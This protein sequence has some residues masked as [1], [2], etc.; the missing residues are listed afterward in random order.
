TVIMIFTAITVFGIIS[1]QKLPVN[2]LPDIKYPS[3]TVWTELEGSSPEQIERLVT[4]P[5]EASIAG[6]KDIIKIKSESKESISLITID[7][8]WGTDMDFAVLYLREKLDAATLPDTAGRPNILRVDP[9]SKPIIILSISGKDLKSV[10]DISEHIIKK[11]IEQIEGVAMADVIGGEEVDIRIEADIEKLN[12]Y[13]L[14]FTNL[15][16]VIKSAST[17]S[18]GGTVKDDVYIY[19][20]V[21]SSEFKNL[22]DIEN[23]LIKQLDNKRNIYVKDVAAV[24]YKSK[25][26]RSF[27]RYNA[28]SS[29]AILIR[30]DGDANAVLVADIVKTTIDELNNNLDVNIN[31]VYDQSQFI[32]DSINNVVS[33]ILLGGLLSF[34]TLFLFLREFKSPFNI[35]LAMPISIFST[36]TLFYFSKISLNLMSLSGFAL[37]IGMLVD[38]SIVVLENIDRHR[39]DTANIFE[40]CYIGVKEVILPVSASTFT[41]IIVF[42]PVVFVSGVAGEL[43]KDQSASVA[44]ALISSLFVSITL[45]PVLYNKMVIGKKSDTLFDESVKS[46]DGPIFKTG[47]YWTILILIYF[48]IVKISK[49]PID[50]HAFAYILFLSVLTDPI[51]KSIEFLIFHRKN[52]GIDFK[53]KIKF[54]GIN[55]VWFVL[56]F[57]LAIPAAYISKVDYFEPIHAF[58]SFSGLKFL[59]LFDNMLYDFSSFVNEL[60]QPYEEELSTKSFMLYSY[61]LG[62]VVFIVNL[63]GLLNPKK[64][65][66]IGKDIMDDIFFIEKMRS[67]IKT[68]FKLI[69]GFIIGLLMFYFNIAIKSFKFI[70]KPV[71]IGFDKS[72][73][74]FEN[75]YHEILIKALNNKAWTF[76]LSI[77]VLFVSYLLMMN[78][79]KR[80]M[81]DVDSR[82]FILSI[83]LN[84]GTSIWTTES[85]IQDY[86]QIIIQKEGVSSAFS[87]G[88]I[89][90]EKSIL[91]GATVYK[92]DIQVKLEDNVSTNEFI[93]DLRKDIHDYNSNKDLDIKININTDV[94]VL[95]EML[96]ADEGDISIKISGNNLNDLREITDTVIQKL[97][98]FNNLSEIKSDFS[99]NKPQISINFKNSFLEDNNLS[100]QEISSYIKTMIKGE[101]ATQITENNK[102]IDI[103][104]GTDE[105][106]NENIKNILKSIYKKNG[107][108]YPVSKL[109]E[110]N[111][112]S[113]PEAIRHESQ[114][115]VITVTANFTEGRL[116]QAVTEIKAEMDKINLYRGM[117][118]DV[119]GQNTEMEKSMTQIIFMFLLSF[120]LVYMVLASQFE[121]LLSPLIIVLSVPFAFIGVAFGLFITGQSINILS[122]IG[123]IM[124]VGI[125]VNDAIVKVDFIENSVK[126]GLSVRDAIID[127][128]R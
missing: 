43:F 52:Q 111:F 17:N 79:E 98:E 7:F 123:M 107:K 1:Y 71:F 121:S 74:L 58:I 85:V 19:D 102:T 23:T 37:G 70:F 39:Q 41:T 53:H 48:S 88:G 76:G 14:S 89:Y 67:S 109:I 47:I 93:N 3:L 73:N 116:D 91:T 95:G 82:E 21:I 49:I 31:I 10:R 2:L 106:F 66:G 100:E 72:Y 34:L 40:A 62:G 117:R 126:A 97:K 94:S 128:S 92:G 90:D 46:D 68:F 13:G 35:S 57:M 120:V 119:G 29:T 42:M 104:V 33:A 99:G 124:L 25:E 22:S 87:T 64:L 65:Y 4:E 75:I 30:K 113:G 50:E 15:I 114:G 77:M 9:A 127:A 24:S 83:E 112:Q 20:L 38:N 60:F 103:I 11:R 115:R 69:F 45:V 44:F 5:L 36:F 28:V 110:A 122:G 101:T 118:I 27:T 18:P 96:Q 80:M 51:I 84:P 8:A 59:S 108:S 61:L 56:L 16:N 32:T 86:E 26:K 78:I 6:L 54:Y 105:K 63:F 55:V 12:V 125:V 81:P